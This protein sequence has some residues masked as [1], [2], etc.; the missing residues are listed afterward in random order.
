MSKEDIISEIRLMSGADPTNQKVALIVEGMDDITFLQK[1]LSANVDLYQS[2]S[3]YTGVREIVDFFEKDN[4]IGICDRDYDLT[5]HNKHIFF[6][7]YCCLEMMLIANDAGFESMCTTCYA[8][9]LT[10]AE[11]RLNILEKVKFI[12]CLRKVNFDCCLE[13]NFKKISISAAYV[14]GNDTINMAKILHALDSNI[15]VDKRMELA[16]LNDCI[17]TYEQYLGVTNGHDFINCLQVVLSYNKPAGG[18]TL[19]CNIVRT[20]LFSNFR[21][22]DFQNTDLYLAL[23]D[24]G[25][26]HQLDILSTCA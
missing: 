22:N 12:S 25:R 23:I 7:D 4:V 20:L 11:L 8:G 19:S 14:S 2:F 15:A 13:A 10:P 18:T 1:R 26:I 3:G 17:T 6:Y 9:S 16:A 21:T 5:Y 24:Y